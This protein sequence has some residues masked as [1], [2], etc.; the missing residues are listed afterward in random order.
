MVGLNHQ[1]PVICQDL[2]QILGEHE[3][4]VGHVPALRKLLGPHGQIGLPIT[5]RLVPRLFLLTVSRCPL[6]IGWDKEAHICNGVGENGM[7]F[8]HRQRGRSRICRIR[9]CTCSSTR[10]RS[11]ARRIPALYGS[12]FPILHGRLG[13]L[14]HNR[15][16]VPYSL[17]VTQL[18]NVL[19]FQSS[20]IFIIVSRPQSSRRFTV[21][22]R[23]RYPS[24]II[25]GT[26]VFPYPRFLR[27]QGKAHIQ[28]QMGIPGINLQGIGHKAV[29]RYVRI[30]D[31]PGYAVSVHIQAAEICLFLISLFVIL[32][33]HRSV[34]QVCCI[35]AAG[36][37]LLS[38]LH[39]SQELIPFS[40]DPS[41]GPG[42]IQ[43]R[44]RNGV[45]IA[46]MIVPYRRPI[47]AVRMGTAP[48]VHIVDL[49]LRSHGEGILIL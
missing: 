15:N 31:I 35:G 18:R 48:A 25:R 24:L 11:C 32:H 1:F 29:G 44:I 38:V 4:S 41:V 5:L 47:T 27:C 7:P 30:P 2:R 43:A 45:V 34:N 26:V 37:N 13:S 21:C 6:G 36:I 46:R 49:V 20:G 28:H 8:I 9:S 19:F 3:G 33:I 12:V 23:L 16:G 17:A 14:V 42:N 10:S 39:L 22:P 40:L